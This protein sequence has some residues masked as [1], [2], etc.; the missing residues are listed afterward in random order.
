M[1]PHMVDVKWLAANLKNVRIF[2]ASLPKPGTGVKVSDFYANF[3]EKRIPG[4][5]F[6]D[7]N[8]VATPH[9]VPHMMPSLNKFVSEM[10]RQNVKPTDHIV[11]YDQI[12]IFGSPRMWYTLQAM[13]HK[14]PVSVLDGGFPA[15]LADTSNGTESGDPLADSKD[16]ELTDEAKFDNPGWSFEPK[17]IVSMDEMIGFAKSGNLERGGNW[18]FVDARNTGRYEGTSPEPDG[19]K[20]GHIPHVKSV[21]WS[22]VVDAKTGIAKSDTVVKEVL[23]NVGFKKDGGLELGGTCGSALS[24]CIVLWSA[25]RAEITDF[26]H[27]SLFDLSWKGWDE[28]GE[29]VVRK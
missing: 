3:K 19:R 18:L 11:C 29:L 20:S 27:M 21:P 15:W 8:K 24:A 5:H 14:G 25:V 12:G 13:G 7:Q 9:K 1:G 2:D 4:A 26:Q 22:T 17:S 6:F 10:A 16:D 23:A 28:N